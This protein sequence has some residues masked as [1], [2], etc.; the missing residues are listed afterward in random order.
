MRAED[1]QV[2]KVNKIVD[3][4]DKFIFYDN[5][6]NELIKEIPLISFKYLTKV[7]AILINPI[8]IKVY[9]KCDNKRIFLL[10]LELLALRIILQK[11]IRCRS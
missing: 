8:I 7:S 3:V 4:S 10:C 5:Q 1:V 11:R 6:T 9:K 2:F